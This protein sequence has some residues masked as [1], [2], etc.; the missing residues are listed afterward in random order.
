MKY[1]CQ[2]Y[3]YEGIPTY[4]LKTEEST[5]TPGGSFPASSSLASFSFL[6]FHSESSR[7]VIIY[8]AFFISIFPNP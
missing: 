2:R 8:P 5:L 4:A 7:Y 6:Q 3:T 1:L